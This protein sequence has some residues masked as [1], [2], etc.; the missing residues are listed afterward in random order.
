MWFFS[1][2]QLGTLQ[3][4]LNANLRLPNSLSYHCANSRTSPSPLNQCKRLFQWRLCLNVLLLSLNHSFIY[5]LNEYDILMTYLLWM[6]AFIAF[7]TL[8]IKK[9]PCAKVRNLWKPCCAWHA[10]S[11]S[12]CACNGNVIVLLV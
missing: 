9:I 6:T 5:I 1:T 12:R 8:M 11:S 2:N 3:K 10:C 4:S 7:N